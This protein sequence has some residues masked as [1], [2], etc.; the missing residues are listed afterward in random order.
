MRSTMTTGILALVLA[1]PVAGAPFRDGMIGM[2]GGGAAPELTRVS[3]AY[4]A[5]MRAADAAAAAAVFAE[6]GTDMAP[7]RGPV[8]GRAAI[9]AY[10]RGLFGTCRFASF[11][12]TETESRI[13][14]DVG[15][16][17]GVSRVAIAGGPAASGKYLV[18]LKRAGNAWKVAYAIH[19]DDAPMPPPAAGH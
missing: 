19:N 18:V 12:L 4:A 14:G 8:R 1:A 15:F 16:I 13:T 2:A 5:A 17:A 7:G 9:E 10:Y 6:D 11:E 3:A